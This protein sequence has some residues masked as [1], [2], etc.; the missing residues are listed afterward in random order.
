MNAK[1][2]KLH[3]RLAELDPFDSG[4]PV[5]AVS[6]HEL[7]G[8]VDWY[9]YPDQ[10]EGNPGSNE[11]PAAEHEPPAGK[12]GRSPRSALSESGARSISPA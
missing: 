7:Y 5:Q 9:Q 6:A 12:R 8:C 11:K 2:S 10:A 3:G 1:P 4:L